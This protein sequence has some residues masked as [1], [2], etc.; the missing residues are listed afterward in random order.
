MEIH[1][2][3]C[4]TDF[5]RASDEALAVAAGM[6]EAFK[7]RLLLLHVLDVLPQTDPRDSIQMPVEEL[8]GR[9]Q[10]QLDE[11]VDHLG[12]PCDTLVLAGR[13]GETIL[14]C[15]HERNAGLIVMST[16]GRTGLM[17]LLMGSVAE[18]VLHRAPCPVTCV[19]PAE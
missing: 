16:H 7:A 4:P 3:L 9:V 18:H 6:A 13:P 12:V 14:R 5:S 11:F 19:R 2:I 15:A 17:R 10:E 8:R 1:T